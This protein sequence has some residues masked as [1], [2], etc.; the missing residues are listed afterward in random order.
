MSIGWMMAFT[1]SPNSW[2]GTPITAAAAAFGG[3]DRVAL[4]AGV[5]LVEHRT[6]PFDHLLLHGDGAGRCRMD[7]HPQARDVVAG[8]LLHR[9]APHAHEHGRH[10]LA[11]GDP[12]F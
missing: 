7:R 6:P 12:V 3:G 8:P 2:L 10:P 5:V 1:S 9:G 4:G 11:V